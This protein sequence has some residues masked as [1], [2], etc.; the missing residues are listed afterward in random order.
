MASLRQSTFALLRGMRLSASP[1]PR[2]TTTVIP[3]FG[4]RSYSEGA[5]QQPEL[6]KMLKTDLKTAMRAKE[7]IWMSAIRGVLG[8]VTNL[9]K[10]GK[11]VETDVQ[12]VALMRKQIRAMQDAAN[13]FKEAN[14]ED[15]VA[16]EEQSIKHLEEYIRKSGVRGLSGDAL[17]AAIRPLVEE[18]KQN[19]Q[20]QGPVMKALLA[21]GG[22]LDGKTVDKAELSTL[23]KKTFA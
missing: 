21:P 3:V 7:K 9:D 18:A 20:A 13:E 19:G 12:V 11:P 17:M 15:L 5:P 14:R 2:L 22:P 23:V 8:E 4:I 16:K 6:I 10:A 1:S